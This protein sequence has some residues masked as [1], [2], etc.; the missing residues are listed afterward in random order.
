[1]KTAGPS[2]LGTLSFH[3]FLLLVVLGI[4]A[5]SLGLPFRARQ[6]PLL[7]GVPTAVLLCLS[8]LGELKTGLGRRF[9]IGIS[10]MFDSRSSSGS[11]SVIARLPEADLL[12][13]RGLLI[14]GAWF[15]IFFVLVLMLGFLAA[16]LLFVPSFLLLFARYPWWQ[17]SLYTAVSSVVVWYGFDVLF[18][19]DLWKGAAPEIVRHLVGGGVLP[20]FF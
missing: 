10:A 1:M 4:I 12:S 6:L 16:T 5:A 9:R 2:R 20:P 11:R 7:I 14:G 3:S 15:C 18:G 13:F 17:I 19:L 8:L